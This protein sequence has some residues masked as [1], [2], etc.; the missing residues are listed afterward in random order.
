MKKITSYFSVGVIIMNEF[1][2]SAGGL[3]AR[4]LMVYYGPTVLF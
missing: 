2:L 3:S 4:T 1:N